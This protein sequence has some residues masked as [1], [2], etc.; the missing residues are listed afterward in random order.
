M[1]DATKRWRPGRGS[2]HRRPVDGRRQTLNWLHPAG[3]FRT[4]IDERGGIRITRRATGIFN[5]PSP[6]NKQFKVFW[7]GIGKDDS[8]TGPSNTTLHQA[9]TKAGIT[10]TYAVGEGR[11]EWTVWRNHLRE[12]AP[13]LFK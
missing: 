1:V 3:L 5:D 4:C 6:I 9:L 12:V 13:L 11:H 10:H 8:L 2:S 7:V